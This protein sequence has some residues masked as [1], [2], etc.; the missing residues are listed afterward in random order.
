MDSRGFADGFARIC[1]WIR[2]DSP[3]FPRIPQDSPRIYADSR[4][5]PKFTGFARIYGDSRNFA[6]D[7]RRFAD[8]FTR[9]RE[10]SRMDIRRLAQD[11]Q[12]LVIILRRESANGD[13]WIVLSELPPVL[14][15]CIGRWNTSARTIHRHALHFPPVIKCIASNRPAPLPASPIPRH[16][17]SARETHTPSPF[18][19]PPTI[20]RVEQLLLSISR[21]LHAVIYHENLPDTRVG[22]RSGFR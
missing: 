9:I 15:L 2:K 17:A 19:P 16:Q 6:T 1:G 11:S 20:L 3:R 8:G 18:T 13:S 22:H 4:I 5:C 12:R 7:I 21:T 14:S 10:S